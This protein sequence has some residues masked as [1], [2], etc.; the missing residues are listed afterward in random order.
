MLGRQ[1]SHRRIQIFRQALMTSRYEC[2]FKEKTGVTVRRQVT[3]EHLMGTILQVTPTRRGDD[4]ASIP[5][6]RL[7]EQN[8]WKQTTGIQ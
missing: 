7:S 1:N 6:F 2:V 8:V 3:S 5:P 4:G